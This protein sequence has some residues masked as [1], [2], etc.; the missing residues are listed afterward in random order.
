[1]NSAQYRYIQYDATNGTVS[2]GDLFRLSD[3]AGQ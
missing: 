1:V 3:L 2:N